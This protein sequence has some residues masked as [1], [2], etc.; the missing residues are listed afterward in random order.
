MERPP[1]FSNEVKAVVVGSFKIHLRL[2]WSSLGRVLVEPVYFAR[3]GRGG[4]SR[5]RFGVQ[6]E[7]LAEVEKSA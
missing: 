3:A 7:R 6:L 4:V 2:G 1:T 5:L